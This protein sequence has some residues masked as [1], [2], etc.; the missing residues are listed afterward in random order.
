[1]E[2]SQL[3]GAALKTGGSILSVVATAAVEKEGEVKTPPPLA[4]ALAMNL[5]ERGHYGASLK[6]INDKNEEDDISVSS[7]KSTTKICVTD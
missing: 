1:M 4:A 6:N 7:S 5:E 2:S 3:A